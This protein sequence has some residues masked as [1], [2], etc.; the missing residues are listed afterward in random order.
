MNDILPGRRRLAVCIDD[1]GLHGGIDEATL[2]LAAQGRISAVSVMTQGP[3]WPASAAPLRACCRNPDAPTQ[4]RVDVGLHLNLTEA[5]PG[6]AAASLKH[7]IVRAGLR[8]FDSGRLRRQFTEQVDQFEAAWGAMPDH[9]DGHQHI[10]Q[11]PQIRNV[12]LEVLEA[13]Y[14]DPARRPWLRAS[15]APDK[16]V[17]IPDRRKAEIISWLGA[18]ELQDAAARRG[19]R[20]NRHLLGVY[21]F[22][23][24]TTVYQGL[25]SQWLASAV[26]GDL[27]M[28]HPA[29]RAPADDVIGP[30]RQV[31]FLVL[32]GDWF[33][34]ALEEA[35]VTLAPITGI[36][37]A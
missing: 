7:V 35:G 20:S 8:S 3:T 5:L 32:R 26:D 36:L 25:L 13:R 22:E 9:V 23:G 30:A 2:A 29:T 19:W 34:S 14:P 21:G 33:A 4:V 1:Y 15:R 16:G 27:L 18:T 11:L 37:A 6:A 31:E 10:H 24:D 28:C 17:Q 12:V